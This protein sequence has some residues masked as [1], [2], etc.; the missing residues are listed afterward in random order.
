MKSEKSC[1]KCGSKNMA[2]YMGFESGMK[3]ECQDCG[4]QGV[5]VIEGKPVKKKGK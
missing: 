4:Y 3:Y 5:L 2:P 1:P